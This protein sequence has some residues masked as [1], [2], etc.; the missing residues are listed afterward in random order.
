MD[1]T[2]F[3]FKKKLR[4]ELNLI[5]KEFVNVFLCLLFLHLEATTLGINW[6]QIKNHIL[7]AESFN[8]NI[9]HQIFDYK[10]TFVNS[11]LEN[12]NSKGDFVLKKRFEMFV[13][14]ISGLQ[15][16]SDLSLVRQIQSI[17]IKG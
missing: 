3:M 2:Y 12:T 1:E 8:T 15:N 6:K 13:L 4:I 11:E 14:N 5:I 17:S 9:S 7:I 10:I 16:K